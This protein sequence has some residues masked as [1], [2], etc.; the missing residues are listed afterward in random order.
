[1]QTNKFLN[2]NSVKRTS[3]ILDIIIPFLLYYSLI[4][5]KLILAWLLL[6]MVVIVRVFLVL[7]S[8]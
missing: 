8:K 7:V 3:I 5:N 2:P 6:G 4:H 1:M